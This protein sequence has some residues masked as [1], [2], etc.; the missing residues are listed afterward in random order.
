MGIFGTIGLFVG[1]VPL[2]SAAT[3]LCRGILGLAFLL[4]VVALSKRRFDLAAI[5]KNLLTLLASGAC[6]GANW[7]LLFEAYKHTSL[8]VATVCYYLAPV[9]LLLCSPLLGEKLTARKLACVGA[10]MAGLVLVSGIITGG[11]AISVGV[12]FGIGAAALYCAVMVLNKKL[13]AIGNYET[14]TVQLLVS[15]LVLLPY[16]LLSGGLDFS[17]F[18]WQSFAMLLVVGIV[19]TGVAYWL[20]FGSVAA[21]SA[22]NVAVFSY[23]DPVVALLCSW[24]VL[25]QPMDLWMAL[26]AALIL[27]STLYSQLAADR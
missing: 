15:A 9:F 10:A 14:T 5:G 18:T 3:A 23:V 8:A 2:P 12:L 16:V 1:M 25:Q 6:L 19:H 24:L 27:G 17:G 26:G 11:G 22:Q 13:Q 21:L 4:I 7:V 20:Y